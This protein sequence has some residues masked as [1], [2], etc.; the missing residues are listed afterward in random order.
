MVIR[1][2]LV[3]VFIPPPGSSFLLTDPLAEEGVRLG[4]TFQTGS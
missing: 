4:G 1:T 3:F 2:L